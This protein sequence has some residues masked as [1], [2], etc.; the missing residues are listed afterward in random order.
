MLKISACVIV[1]NEEANLPR[2]LAC[3]KAIADEMV[4][5]DTGSTDRTAELA[6]EAGASVYSFEWRKDFS[7]A[8]NFAL[9]KAK[10]DWIVFLDADE[11]FQEEDIPQVKSYIESYDG[12]E[13]VAGFFCPIVD[14]DVDRGGAIMFE[15]VIL[16]VFRRHPDIRYHGA[17]HEMLKAQGSKWQV[18]SV[19]DVRIIHTGYSSGVVRRKMKRNLEI[20]LKERERRGELWS[21]AFYLADCYHGME[22]YEEAIGWAK[23]AIESK[24]VLVGLEK[25]PYDVL[26]DSMI[27]LD[28]PSA[29]ICKA[30]RQALE[31]FPDSPDY[32]AD[33]GTAFW[34]EKNY[35]EAEVRFN[36]ALAMTSVG[37]G[38]VRAVILTYLAD[39]AHRRGRETQA[40]DYATEALK[41][42][43]FAEF[44][45]SLLC[46]IFKSLPAAD[47]IQFLNTIYN[48]TADAA[49]LVRVLAQNGLY[50]VC[51]YYDKK[52]E[53]LFLSA[54]ERLFFAKAYQAAVYEAADGMTRRCA[55]ALL[56][57]KRLGEEGKLDGCIPNGFRDPGAGM[58][59]NL[60]T[61]LA[62]LER[63]FPA[64]TEQSGTP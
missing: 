13:R 27:K 58:K 15:T 11:Y 56:A 53:G 3:A 49:F 63:V 7:A 17:I 28:Y 16:R 25:R 43:R 34:K 57:E 39:V 12:E 22:H 47:V 20:L 38:H 32:K 52:S 24:E 10:G 46:R 37:I 2:W 50:E 61:Y 62:Q 59:A 42:V 23:K 55:M 33:E 1:K 41:E 30:A 9:R 54:W 51:L 36:E 29:E 8:K 35:A 18:V 44:A 64:G 6:R 26:L 5:V 45:F 40:L 60:Q 14:I 48:P 21:D 31:K 19:D 4:V